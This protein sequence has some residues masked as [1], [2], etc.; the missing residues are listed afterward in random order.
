MKKILP[1]FLAFVFVIITA[2]GQ[3]NSYNL[4]D[5]KVKSLQELSIAQNNST[6]F[7][8]A[9][10]VRELAINPVLQKTGI[11]KINDTISLDLFDNKKYKACI[12]RINVD[13]NGTITIRARLAGFMF[14]SC[15]ITTYNDESYLTIDIPENNEL[16]KSSYQHQTKKYYLLQFDKK[17]QKVI[18]GAPSLIPPVHN[19]Q[20]SRPQKEVQNSLPNLDSNKKGF[21]IDNSVRNLTKIDVLAE[22]QEHRDPVYADLVESHDPHETITLLIVYTPAAAAWAGSNETNINNTISSLMAQAQLALDNS[23]SLIT[24]DLVHSA[25]LD[26]SELNSAD[27]LSN[28][29]GTDDGYMDNVHTLRNTY[30]ADLVVLLEE[31]DYTGGQGWLLT[32]EAGEQDYAFSLTRIQQASWTFT[33]V[34][35]MG[36]N[37]G[38]HHH[39]LQNT[40][41]GPG[42]FSYSAGWRWTGADNGH[43]CSVMTYVDGSYFDDGID[44]SRVGYFSNPT[45]QYQGVATGDDADADNARN[46]RETGS[47]IADYRPLASTSLVVSP[48]SL[49]LGYA[50]GSTGS[51]NITSNTSW[52]VVNDDASW[53][54]ISPSSGSNNGTVTVM[55]ISANPSTTTSRSE[56]VTVSSAGL[57]S[58]NVTVTQ[59]HASYLSVEP[60]SC[61]VSYNAG[62][63]TF[64]VTSDEIW[65]VGENSDWIACTKSN[66][67]T[68]LA[69]Y[70][71]NF[72]SDQRSTE[73]S[74]SVPNADPAIIS[75]IQEG[76]DPSGMIHLFENTKIKIYPNPASSKFFIQ[77]NFDLVSEITI[78][79]YDN[80]GNLLFTKKVNKMSADESVE[81]DLSSFS[82]GT[83][84]LKLNN[85]N[86]IKIEKVLRQ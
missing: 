63:K 55:S 11:V 16:F 69:S 50:S 1:F 44:H 74:V 25:Q 47:V 84:I 51:L 19:Q 15:I 7:Q 18:E 10:R 8:N 32:T 14:G 22:L 5:A 29:T 20:N 62:S 37:M 67:T 34:H 23:N 38:C 83:Y 71:E 30:D 68:L 9:L 42:L 59:N 76:A 52:T 65:T 28:L 77:P 41:P 49:S 13:I 86:S 17:E 24:I 57:L 75:I 46:L 48:V 60:A 27:D 36:H 70:A 53:L 40:Q 12:D 26:Y 43:Y 31:I 80:L 56:T 81:I 72:S 45:L 6:G 21:I 35:E 2:T 58:Q 66:E 82:S 39:K 3:N 85:S 79:L 61:T 33:T 54:S 64:T 78:S 73:I 4:N